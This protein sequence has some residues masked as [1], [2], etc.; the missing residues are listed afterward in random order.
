VLCCAAFPLL[1]AAG[2]DVG[3][4]LLFVGVTLGALVLGV[5]LVGLGFALYR[6]RARASHLPVERA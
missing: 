1:V 6:R 2:T 5:A 3:I 4:A